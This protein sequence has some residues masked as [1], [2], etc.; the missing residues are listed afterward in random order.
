MIVSIS[1]YFAYRLLLASTISRSLISRSMRMP[2][3]KTL[4]L[5]ESLVYA[6]NALHDELV[7][8][9]KS[10]FCTY[11]FLRYC[12]SLFSL[13]LA[14]TLSPHPSC[15]YIPLSARSATMS[16]FPRRGPVW[17]P[18]L[19]PSSSLMLVVLF[20]GFVQLPE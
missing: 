18:F 20:P 16:T 11:G 15:T 5:I 2:R 14:L 10:G 3:H 4:N 12:P 8:V 9:D 1:P 6:I 17:D 13:L 7:K 19:V